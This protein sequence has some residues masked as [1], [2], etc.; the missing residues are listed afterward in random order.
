MFLH[1]SPVQEYAYLQVAPFARYIRAVRS[2]LPVSL[3]KRKKRAS[4]RMVVNA[5]TRNDSKCIPGCSSVNGVSHSI[6]VKQV[7]P[8]HCS[9]NNLKHGK[10]KEHTHP[11]SRI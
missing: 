4:H 9:K 2:F 8:I 7:E 6:Q 1:L 11:N 10:R 5:G 3:S